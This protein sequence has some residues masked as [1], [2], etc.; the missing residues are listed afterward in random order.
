MY[1]VHFFFQI[2][3]KYVLFVWKHCINLLCGS[4]DLF[5]TKWCASWVWAKT[6]LS[7]VSTD[8]FMIVVFWSFNVIWQFLTESIDAEAVLK[9]DLSL[10]FDRSANLASKLSENVDLKSCRRRLE[11]ANWNVTSYGDW[12]FHVS[13][14]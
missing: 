6:N 2:V 7:E 4:K 13:F 3:P 10:L 5:A 1:N 8:S 9:V 11:Y 12:D 14:R